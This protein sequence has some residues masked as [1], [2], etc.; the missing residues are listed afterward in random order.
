[1]KANTRVPQCFHPNIEVPREPLEMVHINFTEVNGKF[2]M[3]TVDRFSKCAWFV[4]LKATDAR[5]AAVT[6]L[7]RIVTKWGLP[8]V[9]ISDRC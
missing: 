6:F 3:T 5:S 9:I 1:M 4:H 8:K 7:S 2:V